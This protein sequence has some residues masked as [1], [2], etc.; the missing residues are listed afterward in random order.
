MT[1]GL[2]AR[3]SRGLL[4]SALHLEALYY[5]IWFKMFHYL[6][7]FQMVLFERCTC[8]RAI[9]ITLTFSLPP[10]LVSFPLSKTP[11]C[12]QNRIIRCIQDRCFW[13]LQIFP[14]ARFRRYYP[15]LKTKAFTQNFS[16]QIVSILNDP[17]LIPNSDLLMQLDPFTEYLVF[18]IGHFFLAVY[19][20]S[21][22][23]TQ[24]FLSPA[25]WE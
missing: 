4:L 3:V 23:L 16:A 13:S 20:Y 21:A 10:L 24:A 7:Y 17:F 1:L 15:L 12:Q 11:T 2:P 22:F 6:N 18:W 19:I 25:A 14:F 5:L 8:R 9:G